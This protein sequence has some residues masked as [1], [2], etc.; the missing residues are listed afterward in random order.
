MTP[1][2]PVLP[3]LPTPPPFLLGGGAEGT[4]SV[5]ITSV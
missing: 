2:S 1:S 3:Y 4:D 5:C